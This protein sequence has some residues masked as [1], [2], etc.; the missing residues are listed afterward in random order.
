[1][2]EDE[3]AEL[4]ITLVEATVRIAD[5]LDDIANELGMPIKVIVEDNRFEP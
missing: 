3:L 4:L 2:T 1:V 5:N